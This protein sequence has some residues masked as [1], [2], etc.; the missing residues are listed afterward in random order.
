MAWLMLNSNRSK[1]WQ[2]LL[3]TLLAIWLFFSPWV[4]QFGD[5][6]AQPP[7]GSAGAQAA[8]YNAWWLGAIVLLVSVSALIQM[9]LWQEW[10]NLIFGAWIFIAPWVLG[11]HDLR[12]ASFDH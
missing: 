3:N 1:Q 11:F 2:D 6:A 4:L 10:L 12:V 7:A 5:H 8:A 9:Q